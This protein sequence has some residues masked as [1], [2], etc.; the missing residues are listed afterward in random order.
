MRL[1]ILITALLFTGCGVT[2]KNPICLIAC[3]AEREPQ[4][5]SYYQKFSRPGDCVTTV[6]I[7][8]KCE[9]ADCGIDDWSKLEGK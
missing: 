8:G 9:K 3:K 4:T 1:I 2:I 5:S 6:C 7:N